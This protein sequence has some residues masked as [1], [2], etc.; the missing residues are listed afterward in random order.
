MLVKK[1]QN[2]N[3]STNKQ[4]A[5]GTFHEKEMVDLWTQYLKAG[6]PYDSG[7]SFLLRQERRPRKEKESKI[8]I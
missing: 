1:N 8:L 4:I 5:K 3:N 6:E 2:N 7:W